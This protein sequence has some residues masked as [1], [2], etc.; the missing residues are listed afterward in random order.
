MMENIKDQCAQKGEQGALWTTLNEKGAFDMLR[1][2]AL[3]NT[4][5]SQKKWCVYL[6]VRS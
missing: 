4:F 6:Q 5:A 2:R 1:F 3:D